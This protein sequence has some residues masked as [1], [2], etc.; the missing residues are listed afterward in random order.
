MA[1][2]VNAQSSLAERVAAA[3]QRVLSSAQL[4]PAHR[5]PDAKRASADAE[6]REFR[7]A[8]HVDIHVYFQR[9]PSHQEH[10]YCLPALLFAHLSIGLSL[11][12]LR[13]CDRLRCRWWI[14][15]APPPVL[16][17]TACCLAQS[18]SFAGSAASL[19]SRLKTFTRRFAGVQNRIHEQRCS[20]PF[21]ATEA[22]EKSGAALSPR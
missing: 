12:C 15:L 6:R 2:D 5:R 20:I 3:R 13:C 18:G 16:H 4:R 19:T 9:L 1:L 21:L 10:Q 17:T 22:V 7:A 11:S 14:D 8:S